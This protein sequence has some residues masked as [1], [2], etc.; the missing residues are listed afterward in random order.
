MGKDQ[1]VSS[2]WHA[3]LSITCPSVQYH[4]LGEGK[5]AQNLPS[6]VFFFFSQSAANWGG[7]PK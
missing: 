3:F 1:N 2:G 4:S 5:M 7:R 6:G